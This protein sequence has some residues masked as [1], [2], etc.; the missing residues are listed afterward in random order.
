MIIVKNTISVKLDQN[1]KTFLQEAIKIIDAISQNQDIIDGC[2]ALCPFAKFCDQAN[3]E[4]HR[5]CLLEQTCDNIQF[6][7]EKC[8]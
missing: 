1:E 6:I 7:L 8:Q 3:C 5:V 4:H 2:D